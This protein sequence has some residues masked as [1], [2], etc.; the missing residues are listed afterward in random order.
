MPATASA[1][2]GSAIA[3][4][5]ED[6]LIAAADLV[7]VTSDL[8]DV[9]LREPECLLADATHRDTVRK[10]ADALERHALTRLRDWYMLAASSARH[11]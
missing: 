6:V 9:L 8:V 4:V 3:V 2:A 11:R 1:P 5:L 7:G 10:D